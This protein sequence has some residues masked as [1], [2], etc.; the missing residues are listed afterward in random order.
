[1]SSNGFVI[2]MLKPKITYYVSFQKQI[3]IKENVMLIEQWGE[4]CQKNKK[5]TNIEI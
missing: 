4:S 5:K 3:V 2:P 1:V